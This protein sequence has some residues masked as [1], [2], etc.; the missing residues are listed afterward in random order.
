M[1]SFILFNIITQLFF[2]GKTKTMLI[3]KLFNSI[4]PI[5]LVAVLLL[6]LCSCDAAAGPKTE[7]A[8]LLNTLVSITYYDSRDL[9][10]V[11]KALSLCREYEL[12]FS[13]TDSR[14]ELYQLNQERSLT[15]SD[16]L[17]EVL[18]TALSLCE[19]SNGRFE[20]SM[21]MVSS[22]Y[23]FDGVPHCP[24]P[25]ELSAAV[26]QVDYRKIQ[27]DGN[28]VTLENP[29]MVLDLGSIAKGYIADCMKTALME[30]GVKHAIISLGGN[31][32]CIGGKPD[33]SDYAVGIKYP[34]KDSSKMV[35]VLSTRE[36][37]VVTSGV[38]E[39]SFEE[40]GVVFHHLLDSETGYPIQNGLL[41]VSIY[42]P[43]SMLCDALSTTCFTMGLEE[44]LSYV[45]VLDGYEAVFITE[46]HTLHRSSGFSQYELKQ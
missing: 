15:V 22:L 6:L 26:S 24:D 36:G 45:N 40:N 19:D 27:I 39:R 5:L 4:L 23:D 13:R 37:S 42:G 18:H 38:Y 29:E 7:Q 2:I 20:I 21:G 43:C 46:D 17:L 32:L 10:A 41:S 31:I 34:E 9:P 12:V 8:F 16:S 25:D 3:N 11:Q 44:G 28:R 33:G 1:N 14:S 35:A 30:N